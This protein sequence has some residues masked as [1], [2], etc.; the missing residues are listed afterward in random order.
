VTANR[1]AGTRDELER[2]AAQPE[3]REIAVARR[4]AEQSRRKWIAD[5]RS[6]RLEAAERRD[7]AEIRREVAET[8]RPFA[9]VDAS[10]DEAT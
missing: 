7:N 3:D 9:D 2:R 10:P 8:R 5:D 6:G 4:E 1:R